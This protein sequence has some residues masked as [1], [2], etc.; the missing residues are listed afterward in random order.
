MSEPAPATHPPLR[1]RATLSGLEKLK[2]SA[3]ILVNHEVPHLERVLTAVGFCDEVLV[4]ATSASSSVQAVC[5]AVKVQI[6]SLPTEGP[7]SPAERA[8]GLAKHDW[9]LFLAGDEVLDYEAATTIQ[10]L[11]Y[12]DPLRSWRIRRRL[13]VGAREIRFG[14]W[15]ADHQVR[16]FNRKQ[17]HLTGGL[18]EDVAVTATAASAPS[19][20]TLEGSL[21]RYHFNDYADLLTGTIQQLPPQHSAI[22][23]GGKRAYEFARA[24]KSIEL[25]PRAVEIREFDITYIQLPEVHFRIVC[26]KGTYIRSMARDFGEALHVGAYL[27]A[28]CRT[29]IGP[30][31]LADAVTLD[32]IEPAPTA[33][34]KS[35]SIPGNHPG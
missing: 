31:K 27:S 14:E 5:A 17:V 16:L 10:V 3:V 6:T 15:V 19:P 13:Y 25:T 33:S 22:R 30:F 12:T 29:R 7:G 18:D 21:H 35:D 2:V 9:V 26:S 1:R 34:P 8:V 11:D 32:Q 28:L 23:I 20:R 24:G 4:V